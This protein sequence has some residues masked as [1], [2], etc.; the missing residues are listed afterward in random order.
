MKKLLLLL[1]CVP[2]I[3]IGQ[4]QQQLNEIKK[5]G[6]DIESLITVGH[7]DGNL[8]LNDG[9]GFSYIKFIGGD[10]DDPIHYKYYLSH[11][12]II[13]LGTFYFP[14]SDQLEKFKIYLKKNIGKEKMILWDKKEWTSE[15]ILIENIEL[16]DYIVKLK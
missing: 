16:W 11:L 12:S 2:L 5:R 6:L 15:K 13:L 10:Y 1:L 4:T 8:N 14:S 9:D 7:L 3:G